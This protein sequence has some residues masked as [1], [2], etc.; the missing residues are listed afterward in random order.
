[1]WRLLVSL[2]IIAG[3][4]ARS[5]GLTRSVCLEVDGADC[6]CL[7]LP[8]DHA[9]IGTYVDCAPIGGCLSVES[10]W[11]R[12]GVAA[13]PVGAVVSVGILFPDNNRYLAFRAYR[14]DVISDPPREYWYTATVMGDGS[15]QLPANVE[16]DEW[17]QANVPGLPMEELATLVVAEDVS[18]CINRVNKEHDLPRHRC[19][20]GTT[21]SEGA[22][23]DSSIVL[24]SATVLFAVVRRRLSLTS[25]LL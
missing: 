17:C 7:G 19:S 24:M 10:A 4:G 14:P 16:T 25:R 13:Y 2:T 11:A 12:P 15:V 5:F 18:E 23:D 20:S 3:L 6:F 8:F 9:I 22:I 21:C 1:M